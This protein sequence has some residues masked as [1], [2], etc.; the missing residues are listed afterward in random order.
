MSRPGAETVQQRTILRRDG[1]LLLVLRSQAFLAVSVVVLI[2]IFLLRE[3]LP[4]LWEMGPARFLGDNGWHPNRDSAIGLFNLRPMLGATLALALGSIFL[5]APAGLASAIFCRFYAPPA[6]SRPYR[7]LLEILAGIPSVVYGF[8]GLV[9]VVPW[10]RRIAAPGPS[11]LAGILILA[12]MILPTAALLAEASLRSVPRSLTDGAAAL[13]MGRWGMV[14]GVAVP[15]ASPGIAAGIV[16]ALVRAVGE[17]MAVLMVTGNVVQMP[18]GLFDPLRALT[19]NIALEMGYAEGMH[20]SALF[21]S[22][23]A[24]MALVTGLVL[25]VHRLEGRMADEHA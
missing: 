22:G 11:L 23:L 2:L 13:G 15:A 3:S 6:L 18:S 20:R 9:T 17:T 24:L 10:V 7:R 25:W 21:V 12:L 14:W 4:A 16:L 8:W 19:A 1:L 5:A